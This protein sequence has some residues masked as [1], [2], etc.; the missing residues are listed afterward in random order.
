MNDDKFGRGLQIMLEFDRREGDVLPMALWPFIE[1]TIIEA[2]EGTVFELVYT[3]T[4]LFKRGKGIT[5]W[6]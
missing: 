6:P 5:Q 2:L 3:E 4:D 1:K